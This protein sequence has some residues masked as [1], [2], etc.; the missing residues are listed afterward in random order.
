MS[1]IGL[2]TPH[3]PVEAPTMAVH[4]QKPDFSTKTGI[5]AYIRSKDW[6]GQE[7][8]AVKIAVCESGLKSTAY[9]GNAH[10]GDSSV[11]I[12]QINLYGNLAKERPSREWLSDPKN[13]IDYAHEMYLKEGFR[14]WTCTRKVS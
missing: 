7:D 12:F 3:I 8:L 1:V 10:T 5:E 11:G 4:E 6:K 14:P 13:N 2:S 9:N